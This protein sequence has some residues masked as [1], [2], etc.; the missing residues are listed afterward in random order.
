MLGRVNAE[1]EKL[2]LSFGP[3]S[4]QPPTLMEVDQFPP[5]S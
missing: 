5:D 1:L 2:S 3:V 4:F